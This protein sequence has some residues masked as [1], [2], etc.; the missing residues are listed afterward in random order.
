MPEYSKSQFDPPAPIARVTF[1]NSTSNAELTDQELL[2]DTGA[3]ATLVPRSATERLGIQPI[4]DVNYE[5]I[6]FDGTRSVAPVVDLDMVF[7][8][9][10]FRGRYLLTEAE[11]GVLGRDVLNHLK[12]LLDGP[13]QQWSEHSP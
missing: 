1:R 8:N 9:R 3:D 7:L 12:L 6:A 11:Q 5:L 4:T 2:I 13:S 10:R